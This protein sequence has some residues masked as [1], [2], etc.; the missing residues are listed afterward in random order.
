LVSSA[1][2]WSRWATVNAGNDFQQ[3]GP[4]RVERP[5]DEPASGISAV[6]YRPSSPGRVETESSIAAQREACLRT[7]R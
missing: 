3:D 4:A 5:S 2:T 7:V 6:I 1:A